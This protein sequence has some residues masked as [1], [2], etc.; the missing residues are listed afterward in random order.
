MGIP[1]AKKAWLFDRL[2]QSVTLLGQPACIQL[3]ERPTFGHRADE[4]YLSFDHWRSKVICD[5]HSEIPANQLVCLDSIH[6]SFVKME[7]QCWSNDGVKNS[8][9]WELVRNLSAKTLEAFGW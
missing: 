3:Q 6:Q 9:E 4:L 7:R 8:Q 1:E 5:Y 2:K